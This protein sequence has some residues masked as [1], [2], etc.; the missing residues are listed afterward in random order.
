[1]CFSY[2]TIFI[3]LL[4]IILGCSHTEKVAQSCQE[5]DWYEIGRQDGTKGLEVVSRTPVKVTCTDSDQSLAEAIYNNGFDAGVVQFCSPENGFELGKNKREI[6]NVC[7]TMLK[8]AFQERYNQGQR[9]AELTL[10]SQ[11]LN[12]KIKTLDVIINNHGL[13]TATR[14]LLKSEKIEISLQLKNIQTELQTLN[15]FVN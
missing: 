2:K 12:R 7:P 14:D 6:K 11:E 15:N 4:S 9:F 13:E 3:G 10:Q 5:V 1:M 8:S